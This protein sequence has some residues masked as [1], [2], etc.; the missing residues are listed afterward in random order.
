MLSLCRAQDQPGRRQ[1]KAQHA[2]GEQIDFVQRRS[3]ENVGEQGGE[4]DEEG[5]KDDAADEQRGAV[6]FVAL[7]AGLGVLH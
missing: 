5:H 6:D 4:V 7:Q 1:P 2:D 3:V